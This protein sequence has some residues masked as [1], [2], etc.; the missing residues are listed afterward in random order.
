MSEK[1]KERLRGELGVFAKQ[2][3]RKK[4]KGHDPNDRGYDREVEKKIRHMKPED[5]DELLNG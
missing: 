3:A 4:Q 2:Y 5:L 1:R